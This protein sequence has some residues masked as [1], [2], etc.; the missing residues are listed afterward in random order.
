MP[1]RG[2]NAT[3]SRRGRDGIRRRRIRVLIAS[4]V[5]AT[6]GLLSACI[7]DP[8]DEPG[9]PYG[10]IGP[11]ST[12]EQAVAAICDLAG[13]A[14]R[15]VSTQQSVD[16]V[17]GAIEQIRVINNSMPEADAIWLQVSQLADAWDGYVALRQDPDLTDSGTAVAASLQNLVTYCTR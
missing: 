11:A 15:T 9:P 16:G 10:P 4:A 17:A 13:G 12:V 1:A 2:T 6:V 5:L 7:P 8:G 3:D 14:L